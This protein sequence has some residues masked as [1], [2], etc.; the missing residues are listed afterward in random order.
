MKKYTKT[1]KKGFV[2]NSAKRRVARALLRVSAFL[3]V[4]AAVGLLGWQSLAKLEYTA[5]PS[6]GLNPDRERPKVEETPL[7]SPIS[8]PDP[9]NLTLASFAYKSVAGELPDVE[10]R[11]IEYAQKSV[12]DPSWAVV[13]FPAPNT[14]DNDDRSFAIFLRDDGDGKWAAQKSAT[15]ANQEF[16]RDV[17]TLLTEV[18]DDL[19]NP[20]FP[21]NAP[22]PEDDPGERAVRAIE[23]AT[24][25]RGD[26][27]AS[28]QPESEGRFHKVP[29]ENGDEGDGG[30][31][32][33]VYL[34]EE[35]GGSLEVVGIG[36]GLTSAEVPGFPAS[37]AESAFAASPDAVRFAP[38]TPVYDGGSDNERV[39]EGMRDA[40]AE[41]Q[42][43]PGAVGF[44][45]LDLE[46]GDGYGIRPDE[47]FFSASTIKI[48]VMAAVYKK[49]DEG[50]LEY[51]DPILTEE[52]DWAAG[53]GW[54]QWE[55][56]GARA[57]VEDALWLMMTQSDN[58][59]T[60][61]LMRVS[62]G[63]GHVNEVAET[64]GAED[65][66]ITWKVTSERA[67]VPSLDN[68]TTPRDMAN[69]L[70]SIYAGEAAS[71]YASEEMVGLMRQNNLEFWM[72]AGLPEGVRAANKG[73]WLDASYNDVGVVEYEG[74]PYV[75]ATFTKY[76]QNMPNGERT[77]ADISEAV[78]LAQTGQT[79]GEFE[80]EREK[81][82]R[83]AA[84]EAENEEENAREERNDDGQNRE[85]GENEESERGEESSPSRPSSPSGEPDSPEGAQP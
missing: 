71:E 14:P 33:E 8:A 59:A 51:S 9:P 66:R 50:E 79:K 12:E 24:G 5:G 42:E 67:A 25:E 18:P 46:S 83:E 53:A 32:T 70:Q 55:T 44:Y 3:V 57:T 41:V 6:E 75:L 28:E 78:W 35:S 13:L 68:R 52:S 21:E 81:E 62:G 76:G 40:L 22:E 73:G 84:E 27:E 82:R 30:S 69:I 54:L 74:E 49:I 77:L 19:V 2:R 43:Y 4:L 11:D 39:R 38:T 20:L 10:P 48:P 31:S 36:D 65:T 47:T 85:N 61:A 80:D 29:V 37:L 1:K 16:P 58:V 26:W 7:A 45:A 63:P 15:V 64:L 23:A 17:K 60:N 72:E 56:P 34:R